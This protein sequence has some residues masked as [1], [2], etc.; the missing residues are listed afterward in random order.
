MPIF[1]RIHQSIHATS[2]SKNPNR[3]STQ[4]YIH[5]QIKVEKTYLLVEWKHKII[6]HFPGNYKHAKQNLSQ[7]KGAHINFCKRFWGVTHI[8]I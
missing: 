4:R 3:A 8:K 7:G 2:I 1:H 5:H 6:L